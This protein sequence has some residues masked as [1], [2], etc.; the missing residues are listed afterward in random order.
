MCPGMGRRATASAFRSANGGE[1]AWRDS[2]LDA[3]ETRSVFRPLAR[4]AAFISPPPCCRGAD[5]DRI[6]PSQYRSRPLHAVGVPISL[7]PWGRGAGSGR[8]R[9]SR[10]RWRPSAGWRLIAVGSGDG[11]GHAG[12]RFRHS[13][14]CNKC[15]ERGTCGPVSCRHNHLRD[16]DTGRR[17]GTWPA[18]GRFDAPGSH[19]AGLHAEACVAPL[20]LH[21][22]GRITRTCPCVAAPACYGGG[23][24]VALANWQ[25]L[26]RRT[27]NTGVPKQIAGISL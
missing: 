16:A 21:R 4:G 13:V 25:R 3:W 19:G 10:D 26:S 18:G 2:C 6:I 15:H 17:A 14:S 23:G 24:T 9:G 20:S 11:R 8:R 12:R 22:A 27:A 5:S 1:R 7:R